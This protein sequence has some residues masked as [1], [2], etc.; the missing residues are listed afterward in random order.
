MHRILIKLFAIVII[1][2]SL[3]LTMIVSGCPKK[4]QH[5]LQIHLSLLCRFLNLRIHF[6]GPV[7]KESPR[8]IVSNHIS[9]LDIF[10]IGS[11]FP[12]SFL[13]KAELKAWPILGSL[14]RLVQTV[15]VRRDCMHSRLRALRKLKQRNSMLSYC[16]FPEGTTS[17]AISPS[18]KQWHRGHAYLGRFSPQGI[19]CL[20]I[21]YSNQ[22]E[23]AWVDDQ[24]LIP[25]LLRILAQKRLDVF[26]S[27]S[28]IHGP[29][30]SPEAT[31]EQTFTSVSAHAR[32]A[33]RFAGDFKDLVS[34]QP[35]SKP[36]SGQIQLAPFE[37]ML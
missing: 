10:L 35:R 30:L 11:I 4:R 12:T 29:F 21:H 25:H 2:S 24:D 1:F 28:L 17:I 7:P 33:L 3:A 19:Y 8:L 6:E 31:L 37:R 36:C 26:V 15:F 5:R 27:G 18:K 14:G 16:I 9:Y 20:G 22:K 32:Q 13:A 34:N 23:M